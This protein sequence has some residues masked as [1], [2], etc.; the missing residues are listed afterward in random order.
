MDRVIAMVEFEEQGGQLP[1]I[2]VVG[3]D[4]LLADGHHRLAAARRSGRVDIE[5]ALR[6]GGDPEAIALAI[7]LNDISAMDPLTKAERNRGI[8]ALLVAGWAQERIAGA[9]GVHQTTIMNIHNSLAMRGQLP[10]RSEPTGKAGR[11]PK[12]IAVLPVEVHERLNDTTLV[13]IADVPFEQQA[14]LAAAVADAALPEP[15]VREAIKVMRDEGMSPTRAVASVTPGRMVMP[16]TSA[17]VAKQVRRRLERFLEE[18]MMVEGQER[19]FWA[20]LDVLASR[21]ESIP[22]EAGSLA[23]LLAD[24]E[25][26]AH[27]YSSVLNSARQLAEVRS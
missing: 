11:P 20:V 16:A 23:R 22:L 17:E 12:P 7:Q 18:P 25:A 26:K 24:V 9:T 4:H 21:V 6:P 19:D 15:R 3:E 10:K 14:E 2:V 1:P 5:A 8:K 13:R 27:H